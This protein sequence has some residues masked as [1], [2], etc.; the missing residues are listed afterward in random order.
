MEEG[1]EWLRWWWDRLLE[2]R[3]ECAVMA[4]GHVWS[5]W[6]EGR[7]TGVVHPDVES[8][9]I[10]GDGGGADESGA[11]A[12]QSGRQKAVHICEMCCIVLRGIRG[13]KKG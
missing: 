8:L 9:A 12:E 2:T 7:L 4:T 13:F 11:H 1:V 10:L 3:R 5:E 6:Q